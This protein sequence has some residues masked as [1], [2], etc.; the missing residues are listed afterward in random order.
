MIHVVS[1][2]VENHFFIISQTFLLATNLVVD[3]LETVVL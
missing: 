3:K 2:Y 1:T